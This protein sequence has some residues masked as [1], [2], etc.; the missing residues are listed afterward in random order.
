M[1]VSWSYLRPYFN[2]C[3]KKF[4]YLLFFILFLFSFLI[5]FLFCF[6]IRFR[7]RCRIRC[8]IQCRIRCQI[9]CRIRCRIRFQF[10]FW[11]RYRIWFRI[12]FLFWQSYL[13][14]L[15][16]GGLQC[17][18]FWTF[19]LPNAKLGTLDII[20]GKFQIFLKIL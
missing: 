16:G 15:F 14:K 2:F 18:F 9:R 4:I 7:I 8:R 3:E 11:I 1:P 12:Q 17:E 5:Q 10:R 6:R 19:F 13:I 20:F